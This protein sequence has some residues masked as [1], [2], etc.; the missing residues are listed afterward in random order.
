VC[1]EWRSSFDRFYADMPRR[2]GPE[3][4]IDRINND[5]DYEPGNVKWSTAKEQAANRR[6]K[7]NSV[8]EVDGLSLAQI[9]RRAGVPYQS[10]WKQIKKNGESPLMAIGHFSARRRKGLAHGVMSYM[11]DGLGLWE[12]CRRAGVNAGSV[13]ARMNRL[14]VSPKEAIGHFQARGAKAKIPAGPLI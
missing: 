3:Y 12:A 7:K 9:C 1:E 4:S 14:G 5:G 6:L 8:M 2:P 13:Y 10:V 11:V